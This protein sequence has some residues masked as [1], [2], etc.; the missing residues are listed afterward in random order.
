MKSKA[1]NYVLGVGII[2]IPFFNFLSVT[3]LRQL[4]A[5]QIIYFGLSLIPFVLSAFV[6]SWV[7][8]KVV[9]RT[10]QI[11]AD[12]LFPLICTG[13]YLQFHYWAILGIF[14]EYVPNF[15]AL[16]S[17]VLSLLIIT[18]IV[19]S[20][21]GLR[22]SSFVKRA[23]TIFVGLSL[24][25]TLVPTTGDFKN[26]INEKFVMRIED[27]ASIN[28]TLV[29]YDT[30]GL[31][32]IDS[33]VVSQSYPNIYFVIVDGMMSLANASD[34]GIVDQQKELSRLEN[35]GL[36]Y[37]EK[38]QSTYDNTDYTLASIF[39]LNYHQS[40]GSQSNIDKSRFA[41][42]MF[43][44]RSENINVA[45]LPLLYVLKMVNAHLVWQG[46]SWVG[47]FRS[48][49]WLCS[50]HFST[51][52][53]PIV[54]ELIDFL[55]LVMPFYNQSIIGS[56]I[57]RSLPRGNVDHHILISFTKTLNEITTLDKPIFA[58]VHEKSPHSS[59]YR[60]ETCERVEFEDALVEEQFG[61][62]GNYLCT[63]QE[64]EQ[65]LLKIATVD[66]HALVVIQADHGYN[67]FGPMTLSEEKKASYKAEIFNLIKAPE[68][69]FRKYGIPRSNV[70]SIR[71]VLNCAYGI[72][73]PFEEDRHI[74]GFPE[75]S[76]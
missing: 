12:T 18:W 40:S 11:K 28:S 7:V 26:Y 14:Q 16:Q 30:S 44:S 5:I 68:T 3:N 71:F 9:S 67:E 8:S 45:S 42:L 66:P 70:N 6:F 69:C 17:V 50:Q 74:V 23:L 56:Y 61:Y 34:I 25:I 21:L 75:A 59:H 27:T 53:N 57:A 33:G 15:V 19:I 39:K 54:T 48:S 47:C 62:R 13:F 55:V 32:T 10:V 51:T 60:S 41:P 52:K 37:I 49:N 2:L 36:T 24:A 31:N 76:M 1:G 63:L 72:E 20:V 35:L 58:F 29:L 65:F 64:I 46:N 73:F 38:S 43:R 22:Y 4:T